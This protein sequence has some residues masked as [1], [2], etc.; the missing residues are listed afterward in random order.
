MQQFQSAEP[1]ARMT[2]EPQSSR[3]QASAPSKLLAI[4]SARK[5]VWTRFA[6]SV[7]CSAETAG[8]RRSVVVM[9]FTALFP[10]P[11]SQTPLHR[12]VSKA[13]RSSG[14]EAPATTSDRSASNSGSSPQ[15][16]HQ[17]STVAT[18]TSP[19]IRRCDSACASKGRSRQEASSCKRAFIPSSVL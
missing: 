18:A 5:L 11:L 4:S 12:V 7:Y 2:A 1:L 14:S 13:L 16:F 17:F 8:T 10:Q 9:L 6:D 3:R 15:A 19:E